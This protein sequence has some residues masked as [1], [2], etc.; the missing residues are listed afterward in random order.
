M[1]K[2]VRADGVAIYVVGESP[3]SNVIDCR[4]CPFLDMEGTCIISKKR[5]LGGACDFGLTAERAKKIPGDEA[6]M[7]SFLKEIAR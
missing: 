6:E 5:K 2:H 1:N 7:I 3:N 4:Q